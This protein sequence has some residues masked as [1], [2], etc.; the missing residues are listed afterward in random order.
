MSLSPSK[1]SP[2]GGLWGRLL[3]GP[4]LRV[5]WP[6]GPL[7]PSHV[8]H[9]VTQ[10]EART[11]HREVGDSRGERRVDVPWWGGERR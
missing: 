2:P 5:P 1:G 8:A 11:A 9:Q 7:S 4:L 10:S 3:Q 6:W